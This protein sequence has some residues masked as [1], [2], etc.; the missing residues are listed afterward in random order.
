MLELG[1]VTIIMKKKVVPTP[2]IKIQPRQIVQKGK[3]IPFKF[4]VLGSR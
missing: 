1:S 2:K 3:K 4:F